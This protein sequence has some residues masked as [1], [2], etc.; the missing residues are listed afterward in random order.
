[1]NIMSS[2]IAAK[3]MPPNATRDPRRRGHQQSLEL[4]QRQR[5]GRRRIGLVTRRLLAD[6]G[7]DLVVM[8]GGRA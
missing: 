6:G 1:L 2:R 5:R 3:P 4:I 8:A 7:A